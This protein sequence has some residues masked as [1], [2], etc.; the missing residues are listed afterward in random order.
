VHEQGVAFFAGAASELEGQT[1]FGCH[2]NTPCGTNV[3]SCQFGVSA[4]YF[5]GVSKQDFDA[6]PRNLLNAALLYHA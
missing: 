5:L 4:G 2:R 3:L 6:L 1:D